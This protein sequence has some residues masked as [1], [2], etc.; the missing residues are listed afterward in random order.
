MEL[1]IRSANY[2][3]KAITRQAQKIT[4]PKYPPLLHS[5]LDSGIIPQVLEHGAKACN[6][7]Q[8]EGELRG[9][10][11]SIRRFLPAVPSPD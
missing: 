1:A 2:T 5:H 10:A 4:Y 6:K 8:L 9:V 3:A 7:P 11:G